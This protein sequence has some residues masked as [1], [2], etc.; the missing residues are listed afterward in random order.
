MVLLLLFR[1]VTPLFRDQTFDRRLGA[2]SY[3]FV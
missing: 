2:Y 1:G 3:T